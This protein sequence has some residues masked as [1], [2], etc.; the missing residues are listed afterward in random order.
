MALER[1]ERLAVELM[2]GVG[3]GGPVLGQ[4]RPA[5][6]LVDH[7]S[8]IVRRRPRHR[9]RAR[10]PQPE[11]IDRLFAAR[12]TRVVHRMVMPQHLH[13]ALQAPHLAA[14]EA[15]RQPQVDVAADHAV[16]RRGRQRRQRRMAGIPADRCRP[17]QRPALA[18]EQRLHGREQRARLVGGE[19]ELGRVAQR[20]LLAPDL[21]VA[22]LHQAPTA[23]RGHR[24]AVGVGCGRRQRQAAVRPWP[25]ARTCQQVL[26]RQVQRV[27]VGAGLEARLQARQQPL[28]V[29]Q[30]QGLQRLRRR[31]GQAG[32]EGDHEVHTA[33]IGGRHRAPRAA[34]AARGAWTDAQASVRRRRATK[35]STPRPASIS[36]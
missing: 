18:R 1:G 16:D 24:E 29:G 31:L 17:V 22:G 9:R 8:R 25:A 11:R 26:V 15:V 3:P 34:T 27:F 19:A 13:L 5:Q 21:P 35:A 10:A 4:P 23:A 33:I 6:P 28:Q 2:P 36:A 30:P 14:G 20:D 7:P 32:G 12:R